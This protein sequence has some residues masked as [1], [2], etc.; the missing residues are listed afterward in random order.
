MK[1]QISRGFLFTALALV[2]LTFMLASLSASSAAASQAEQTYAY[3]FKVE[4]LNSMLESTNDAQLSNFAQMSLLYSLSQLANKSVNEPILVNAAGAAPDNPQTANVNVAI[5]ELMLSG[6]TM[7]EGFYTPLGLENGGYT[8]SRWEQALNASAAAAGFRLSFGDVSGFE[9]KQIDAWNVSVQ[10]ELPLNIT[11]ADGSFFVQKVLHANATTSIEG[12]YDPLVAREDIARRAGGGAFAQKQMFRNP[13]YATPASVMPRSLANE[14][15]MRMAGLGWFYGPIM[16]IDP[17]DIPTMNVSE[18]RASIYMSNYYEGIET[19][20]NLFGAV[21]ITNMPQISTTVEQNG[22]NEIAR[23]DEIKCVNCRHW[24][25]ESNNGQVVREDEL[26]VTNKVNFSY[27]ATDGT[28]WYT[29][30]NPPLPLVN[31]KRSV[32]FDNQYGAGEYGNVKEDGAYHRIFDIENLRD[33]A[34]CGFYVQNESAS[35]FFQKMVKDDTLQLHSPLGIESFVVGKWAGGGEDAAHNA[36]SRLDRK[37]YSEGFPDYTKIKGMPGCKSKEMCSAQEA[38]D[39]GVGHFGLDRE[40]IGAYGVDAISC[41][42]I[43]GA[44][45]GGCG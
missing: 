37:F 41:S 6:T 1:I 16:Q 11:D 13:D 26:D 15:N 12:I 39:F 10:F 21:I 28:G 45:G 36:Y 4:A 20:G 27:I 18:A 24:I 29:R 25:R 19:D 5:K 33:M 34:V 2:L 38:I 22:G 42:G 23:V 40:S 9:V 30:A 35:S 17:S 44:N 3:R 32:L 43:N 31:G 8:I 7:P 14:S